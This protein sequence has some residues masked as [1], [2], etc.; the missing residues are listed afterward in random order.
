MKRYY[1]LRAT[2][3]HDDTYLFSVDTD[4]PEE[5]ELQEAGFQQITREEAEKEEQP[6]EDL[7]EWKASLP[8]WEVD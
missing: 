7:K 6:I 1:I 3:I 8:W 2:D 4:S 5:A